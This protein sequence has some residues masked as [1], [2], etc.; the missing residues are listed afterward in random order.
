MTEKS[1]RAGLALLAAATVA[2]TALLRLGR[3]HGSAPDERAMTLPGDEI[4]P[5]PDVVTDHAI[6][7]EAPPENVWPWLVQMGWGRSG[8]Y[9]ARWVDRLLFPANGPSATTILPQ[10]QHL[11]A[12]D[13]VPDGAPE[14]ECGFVV[15]QLEPQRALVLHSTSH[16]PRA[17]RGRRAVALDWSWAFVLRPVAPGATR[18]HFRSRWTTTPW[19][20]ALG[21]RLALVPADFLMS[22]DML[23][24]VRRRAEALSAAREGRPVKAVTTRVTPR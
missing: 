16:L 20:L 10:W 21:G 9:T 23:N 7:I 22:R 4:V 13:F 5:A 8:W 1:L 24:G 15:E 12:G 17:W 2:E 19:W 3:A 18:F 6:T 14:T 11:A